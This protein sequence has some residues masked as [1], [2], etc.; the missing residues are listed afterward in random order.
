MS[1]PKRSLVLAGGGMRVAYQAGVLR[2]LD[3]AGLTFDH[4]DGTSGGTINLAMMLSGLTPQEMC[5]RWRALDVKEFVSFLPWREYLHG[6]QVIALGDADGIVDEVFPRLGID[7]ERIRATRSPVGTFNVCN[8]T[9]KRNEIITND[10]MDLDLL[11][12]GIS[13]PIFMPPVEHDGALYVDSVWIRDANLVEAFRRGSEEIWLVWCIGN[14]PGYHRGPFRQYV[15]MM[16]LSASGSLYEDLERIADLNQWMSQGW[17]PYGQGQPIRVHVIKP[18]VELPL[19]PDFHA[20][21]ID[22]ETLIGLGYQ[23]AKRYL[24]QMTSEGNPLDVE[25]TRMSERGVGVTFSEE[26]A[27]SFSLQE[28]DP[29]Q[30]AA[31]GERDNTTLTLRAKADVTNLDAFIADADHEARLVGEVLVPGSKRPALTAWGSFNITADPTDPKTKRAVY[32]QG[33]EQDGRSYCLFGWK[34]LR[35]DRGRDMWKD[36]GT[37]R[38]TLHE[39]SSRTGP[40]VG[41]GVLQ[42]TGDGF[43]DVIKSARVTNAPTAAARAKAVLAF[44]RFFIGSLW[45]TYA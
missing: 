31:R 25:A 22:A 30:G 16:E 12:A 1:P 24:R 36:V 8:F 20:G 13:L 41:A 42:V 14:S 10:A 44:G 34:E 33:F 6:T 45:E 21:R 7:L 3:E 23:D 43:S 28:T 4:V 38:A 2:A 9:D 39:G 37:M 5:E 29:E 27:G 17:A 11:V 15:H 40:V 32:E 19:D 18:S 35:D 26:L